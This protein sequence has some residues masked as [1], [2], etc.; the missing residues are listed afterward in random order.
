MKDKL[1]LKEFVEITRTLENF[2]VEQREKY[3]ENIN[4]R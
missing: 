1:T 4:T 3:S 2:V